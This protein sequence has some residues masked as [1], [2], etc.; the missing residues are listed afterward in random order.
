M[1]FLRLLV[2]LAIALFLFAKLSP[3]QATAWRTTVFSVLSP[4]L[5]VARAGGDWLVDLR[6]FRKNAREARSLRSD[7]SR[8]EA[9][10]SQSEELRLENARLTQLLEIRRT[11]P[12]TLSDS[13]VSR[14]IARSPSVWN[15][16]F[17]IDKGTM[18]GVQVGR[19][20]LSGAW[21]VGRVTE[22]GPGASKVTLLTDPLFRI[23]AIVQKTRDQGVLYGTSSGECR[24]KY[25]PL[26]SNI[27]ENDLVETAGSGSTIPKAISIGV[28]DRIWKE[29]G[30]VYRVA[31]VR[32]LA[33][34]A[35]IEEAIC[36]E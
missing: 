9:V 6:D 13:I 12:T 30:Q 1:K 31:R 26:D 32:P 17:F 25:L 23:G 14:V 8:A 18:Q 21:L 19:A 11:L 35:R 24:L 7:V 3:S 27:Q 16:A 15:R 4:V 28:I 33:D 22:T 2:F 5:S 36:V 34:L 20:V 10:P 29:P